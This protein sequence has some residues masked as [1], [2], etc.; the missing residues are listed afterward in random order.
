MANLV[1]Y[2]SLSGV[3]KSMDDINTDGTTP[4]SPET[5]NTR[6]KQLL[7]N[8]ATLED[9]LR[10]AEQGAQAAQ[11]LARL[12]GVDGHGSGLD[13][14]LLDGKHAGEFFD[15][16]RRFQVSGAAHHGFEFNYA[17]DTLLYAVPLGVTSSQR[18][19]LR[20]IRFSGFPY[21]GKIRVEVEPARAYVVSQANWIAA[22]DALLYDGNTAHPN[23]KIIGQYNGTSGDA[24]RLAT[25]I[26]WWVDL[27]I[28]NK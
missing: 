23:L 25:P 26:S 18:V 17:A 15:T 9:L 21:V 14:D 7:D 24:L 3:Q 1:G 22:P 10:K 5:F 20:R 13:A 4:A 8:D 11:L 6:Y 12:K 19:Y 16:A 28:V 27:E 2:P